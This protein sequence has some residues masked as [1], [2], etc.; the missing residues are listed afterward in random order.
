[1]SGAA[2]GDENCIRISYAA[3]EEDLRTAVKNIA[4]FLATFK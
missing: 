4:D 2:F 1:V 3:S